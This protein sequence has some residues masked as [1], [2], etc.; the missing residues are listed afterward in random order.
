MSAVIECFSGTEK[1]APKLLMKRVKDNAT[2]LFEA[3]AEKCV[4]TVQ[5]V[6]AS[7]R[8]GEPSFGGESS[9]STLENRRRGEENE[10]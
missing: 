9:R 1:T 5:H 7:S 10:I 3:C 8:P 2:K 4:K 6:L